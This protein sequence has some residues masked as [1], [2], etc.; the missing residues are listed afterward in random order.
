MVNAST[1]EIKKLYI[2]GNG[3]D[4]HHGIK[5][6]YKNFKYWLSRN[7]KPVFENLKRLYRNINQGWWG[8]FEEN[9]ANF[10]P[11]RYPLSIARISHI[12]QINYLVKY[13]GQEG[14]DFIDTLE[15]YDEDIASNRY[16]RAG[17]IAR[18]E[19]Q[20]LKIDLKEAFGDWVLQ[21]NKPKKSRKVDL[22]ENTLFFTFNYTRTLED[23]YGIEDDQVVHLHGSVDNLRFIIG[24]NMTAEEMMNRDFEKNVYNRDPEKDKGQDDARLAMFEAAEE[25]KKPVEG[26]ISDYGSAFNSLKGIEELEILGISYSPVDI[27]YMEEVFDIAGKGIKVK[28]GWHSERDEVNAEAFAQ[29]MG[30]S[31]WEKVWF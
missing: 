17:A 12:K 24:H 11:D 4:L 21:L 2:L 1:F 26:V 5:C 18:F 6:S 27:P 7:R 30:L 19:M 14:R 23:L 16:R 15:Y 20:K 31:N 3:F 10:D 29:M 22:D 13:Y 9:L 25:M 28:L 8:A